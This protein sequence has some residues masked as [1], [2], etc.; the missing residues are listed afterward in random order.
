MPK[1]ILKQNIFFTEANENKARFL[2]KQ[3]KATEN[4]IK[5]CHIK[6]LL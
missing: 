6:Y 1:H 3:N 5:F 4:Q 2:S